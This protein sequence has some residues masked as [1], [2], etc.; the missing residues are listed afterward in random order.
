MNWTE[1]IDNYCERIDP[2]FWAEPV[3][4]ITNA[5]FLIAALYMWTR[6]RGNMAA[7]VLAIILF[8]IGVG[9]FLFHTF[10]HRWSAVADVVPI[11][12]FILT[13]VWLASRDYLRLPLW[14]VWMVAIL[15]LPASALVG[16][17]IGQLTGPLNGSIGYVPVIPALLIFAV[18]IQDRRTAIGLVIAA[19]LLAASLTARSVDQSLCGAFPLGTHFAWHILNGVLLGWLI[20]VYLEHCRRHPRLASG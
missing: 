17:G 4:A 12:A 10:A 18:L 20:H 19:V 16:S 2:S 14:A 9:S 5:A 7:Q 1:A 8:A 13:Y 3:N 6:A 15:F 11:V